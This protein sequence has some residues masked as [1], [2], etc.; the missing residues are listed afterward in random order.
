[1]KKEVFGARGGLPF[2]SKK[3]IR[4]LVGEFELCLNDG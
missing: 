4:S 1:M 3:L 2:T